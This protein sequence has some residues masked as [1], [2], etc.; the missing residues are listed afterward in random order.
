LPRRLPFTTFV[1]V[2]ADQFLLLGV[3]ADHRV[4]SGQEPGGVRVDVPELGV[5]VRVLGA[6]LGLEHRPQPVSG[7]A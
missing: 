6:F 2:L 5:T 1:G 7:L 4:A 3:D